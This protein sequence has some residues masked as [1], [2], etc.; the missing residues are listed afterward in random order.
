MTV[1][2]LSSH[3]REN[4]PLIRDQLLE[5]TYKPQPV[6]RVKIPKATGGARALGIPMV[7]D[8]FIQQA[9]MQILQADWD[10]TFS[11]ASYGFRPGRSAHQAI[12]KAQAYATE[13]RHWVVDIDLEKFFDRVNHDI[14]MGMVAKRVSDRRLLKLIR[15]FLTAGVLADG[16]VSPT[17][18]GTPQGGPLPPLLSNLMLD[19]LDR[20]LEA[21]GHKHVRFADDCNIYVRSPRAGERVMTSVTQF[22][23]RRLKLRVNE[24]KSAVDQVHRRKFLGFSF[25]TGRWGI[26][27][28]IARQS[29]DR[30]KKQVRA[31]TRRNRGRSLEQIIEALRRYLGGWRAYFGF[32]E[33]AS[34]LRE[35][36]MWIRRRLRA[37]AW[38]QWKRGWNR[39]AEL[40][41][42]GVKH[43]LAAQTASSAHGPWRIAASP[44][45]NIALSNRSFAR[46]G[47]PSLVP[48]TA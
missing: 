8:R 21:R 40:T 12:S 3:L 29:L 18:E 33:T 23:E 36:D 47:L 31:L 17:D 44:A 19:R 45:L 34:V 20:E 7:L 46:M 48:K 2:A 14:L 5:G 42:R 30:F 9:V 1:E 41:K 25:T 35:L 24:S 32:C 13:G 10:P 26:K 27:R 16:F 38:Y 39:Y 15:G 43:R 28:R 37:I 4:W 22:L 11:K 6:L